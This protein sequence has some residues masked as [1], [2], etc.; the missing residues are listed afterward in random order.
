MLTSP[1]FF[2]QKCPLELYL[3]Q[4]KKVNDTKTAQSQASH[5]AM[6]NKKNKNKKQQQ[7]SDSDSDSDAEPVKK[8]KRQK[9]KGKWVDS[10]EVQGDIHEEDTVGELMLDEDM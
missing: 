6:K 1:P 4:Q 5:Q 10:E 9:K 7:D 8:K 2:L 3:K